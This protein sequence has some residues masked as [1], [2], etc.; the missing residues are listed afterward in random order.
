MFVKNKIVRL[1]IIAVL[2]L[3]CLYNGIC[4]VATLHRAVTQP[5]LVS[6]TVRFEFM[7]YY[8][9]SAVNGVI[10]LFSAVLL[11]FHIF[12]VGFGLPKQSRPSHK[13]NGV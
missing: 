2:V 7:G 1:T 6:Q 11:K 13:E 12:A 10:C 8:I 4:C 5:C 9:M 3:I